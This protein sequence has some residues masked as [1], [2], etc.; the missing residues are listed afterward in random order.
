M[1]IKLPYTVKSFFE[2][3]LAEYEPMLSPYDRESVVLDGVALHPR[4]TTSGVQGDAWVLSV[5]NC[6]KP[7]FINRDRY[8]CS[9]VAGFS[10]EKHGVALVKTGKGYSVE[11]GDG[12]KLS[13]DEAVCSQAPGAT[14]LALY[15]PPW[16]HLITASYSG[17]QVFEKAYK[18]KPVKTF[19]GY[20]SFSVVFND[21]RSVLIY[22]GKVAEAGFPVEA[23]AFANNVILAKSSGWLVWMEP[24]LPKP[25]I[26]IRDTDVE[27]NGFHQHLPVF[28]VNGKLHRLEGGALVDLNVKL[29]EKAIA[30]TR[31]IT[32]I[33]AGDSLT[34]Y[35]V[36][37]KQ[38]LNVPKD[39]VS[40]CWAIEG[41]V[42]CCTRG[43]CGIVEPGESFIYI[44][45]VNS[46]FKEQ[47]AVRLASEAPALAIYGGKVN[48]VAPGNALEI[49]DERASVLDTHVFHIEIRHLLGS[50]DV[51]EKSPPSLVELSAKV[52]A[53][54]STGVHVCGGLSLLELDVKEIKAPSRVRIL[55]ENIVLKPGKY[56]ICIDRVPVVV[57]PTAV[58][59]VSASSRKLSQIKVDVVEIPEPS[60]AVNVEHVDDHSIVRI[61]TNAESV[62][63]RLV[64]RNGVAE[65]SIPESTIRNC[66]TPAYI[67]VELRDKG[68]VY[69]Y[70]RSIVLKGLLDHVL[71]STGTGLHEYHE[72]GFVARYV[73]PGMPE[74]NPLSGFKLA[75]GLSNVDIRF[76]SKVV[77]RLVVYDGLSTKSYVV[78]PGLNTVSAGFA[79][80]YYLVFDYGFGKHLYKLE[81]PVAEQIKTAHAH[82]QALYSALKRWLK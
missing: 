29:P 70:R 23:V 4:V 64:C 10:H 80:V 39:E 34:A 15:D 37:F 36:N 50:A 58:D 25:T 31:D 61:E 35:D 69:R 81:Y 48:R 40:R 8:V 16:T 72:G 18:G 22:E 20:R 59:T 51:L 68:F 13:G 26:L 12:L 71:N 32:V 47:H 52:K 60:L 82:A 11:A 17:V 53:Y 33:D 9:A 1:R 3:P 5:E 43:L 65:L 30:T 44:D 74:V 49:R 75:V 42:F 46:P 55:A 6:S 24:D 57:E 45:P 19:T 28:S 79:D 62:V 27:F 2:L 66:V 38:V 41:K 54:V 21:G 67:E 7:V 76:K 14:V 63:A 73:V 56:S 78:R 77:G